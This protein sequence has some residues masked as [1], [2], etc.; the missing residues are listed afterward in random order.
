MNVRDAR[1]RTTARPKSETLQRTI[2]HKKQHPVLQL[3]KR[4]G[5]QALKH[6][7]Q[8]KCLQVTPGVGDAS[9][10]TPGVE[11][12]INKLKG[13]G[14]PLDHDAKVFFESRFGTP[15]D[16]IRVHNDSNANQLAHRVNAKAF[17]VGENIV[18]GK[19]Q[20]APDTKRSRSLLAHELA[21]TI[22]QRRNSIQ[23]KTIQRKR[24]KWRWKYKTPAE[25]NMWRKKLI[26]LRLPVEHAIKEKGGYTFY[27]TSFTKNEIKKILSYIPVK[28][29]YKKT[30]QY[31]IKYHRKADSYY[32]EVTLKCPGAIPE[33]KGFY[34]YKTCFTTGKKAS[35]FVK[36]NINKVNLNGQI[37]KLSHNQFGV[38]Y[39]PHLS[40]FSAYIAG[41]WK[42]STKP[43]YPFGM[44]HVVV[45]YNKK[46]RSWV[47]KLTTS[48]PKG[49][50]LVGRFKITAYVLAKESDFAA[51]PTVKNPCGLKGTFRK[52]FLYNTGK[53]P[54]GVK[55]QGSGKALNGKIIHYKKKAGKDCFEILPCPP[56]AR[57][58]CAVA[59]RTVAVDPK[60]IGYGSVLIIEGIGKRVA[61][62]TGGGIKGNHID[63]YYGTTLSW[64]AA[65]NISLSNKLVCKKK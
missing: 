58:A 8:S 45:K 15:F 18:F 48:C 10:V 31:I 32:L 65:E 44:H 38:Y 23:P 4:I 35:S 53:A 27:Y 50:A 16:G 36:N 2:L 12:K 24:R 39:A 29:L 19:G 37:F 11:S 14:H 22:Q 51:T 30:T 61:E 59:G 46:Y 47:Y 3:Q 6:L 17:A 21:H 40:R 64:K 60:T 5:N 43:A 28:F 57:A 33:K 20:Y 34:V 62:D 7:L 9:V 42:A 56:P 55:M 26:K 52:K 13:G 1:S 63:V 25:A 41:V 49:Y 54:R